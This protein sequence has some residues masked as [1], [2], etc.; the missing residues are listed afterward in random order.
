M[1]KETREE[2]QSSEPWSADELR[3]K[4]AELQT[5]VE[6]LRSFDVKTVQERYD[7]RVKML[8]DEINGTIAEIY[9]QNTPKYWQNAIASLDNLPT[10]IGGARYPIDKVRE[11]Y[12]M[13]IDEAM[14]KLAS[15]VESLEGKLKDLEGEP[16]VEKQPGT[17]EATSDNRRVFV[18]HGHDDGAKE[19]VTRFLAKLDMK[20]EVLHER[21]DEGTTV[22]DKLGVRAPNDFAVFMLTADDI[23]QSSPQ[24]NEE[25]DVMPRNAM[26]DLGFFLGSLGRERVVVLRKGNGVSPFDYYG[27][28]NISLDDG[29]LWELLLARD[30][31]RAGLAIDMNK[32]V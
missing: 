5:R 23:R 15:L 20:P 22:L 25:K 26:F 18:V 19:A 27:V 28:R 10:V 9:G 3:E 4:I 14:T 8:S 17:S 29:A 16:A 11:V 6:D 21:P 7:K 24:Q 32:A 31:K 13:G 2:K 30:M 1:V 12:Q